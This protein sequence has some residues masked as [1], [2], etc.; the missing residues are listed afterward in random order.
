MFKR[1][2]ENLRIFFSIHGEISIS[3]PEKNDLENKDLIFPF[4]LAGL[5]LIPAGAIQFFSSMDPLVRWNRFFA[6]P[7]HAT[8]LILLN[9]L[10]MFIFCQFNR[11]PR[12]FGQCFNH[13]LMVFSVYPFLEI[14]NAVDST[15]TAQLLALCGILIWKTRSFVET[16]IS[17]TSAFFLVVYL[18]F[19]WIQL[20][21][22]F[23]PTTSERFKY[24]S[25]VLPASETRTLR[26]RSRMV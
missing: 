25:K 19:I 14:L 22:P 17:K 4:F 8:I 26:G 24:F 9:S 2:I 23:A 6:A 16:T 10:L 7:L 3:A 1:W 20:R 13:V 5:T 11:T 15:H 21:S 18:S 12:H